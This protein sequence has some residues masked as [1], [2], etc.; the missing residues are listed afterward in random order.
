MTL[1]EDCSFFIMIALAIIPAFILGYFKKSQKIYM[2]LLS[3]LF[4][5]EALITDWK[6][7][8]YFAAYLIIVIHVVKVYLLLRN[9]YGRNKVIY[10]HFLLLSLAPLLICKISGLFQLSVFGF[11]GIS[12]I[13]FKVVQMVI[14]I[15]DGLIKE[16]KL[17]DVLNFFLFFPTFSSGPI[18]RS[19]RFTSDLNTI[20]ERDEYLKLAGQGLKK[21]M[22]GAV[23][24]FAFS[25]VAYHFLTTVFSQSYKPLYLIG[26]AYCYGI[27]MFFDFAGY[28]KMAVGISNLLSIKTPDNFKYPFISVDMNDFW[29]RWHISLSQ[30]FRDFVFSRFM[31]KS[32]HNKWFKNRLNGAA[33][34][35]IINMLIMGLWHGLTSY[36]IIYG[37]YHGV[38][39]AL[40]EIYHKKSDFYKRNKDK[41]VYKICSWF[42]TLNLVMFGFLIFSGRAN[43]AVSVALN[44][45][46]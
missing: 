9:K 22:I 34:G 3:L 42:I 15:Y 12:Y 35:L 39:L 44:I 7:I 19:R 31:M 16:I 6:Q 17:F 1:F 45:L 41:K 46:L 14:E 29:N 30:W 20:P 38:L 4:V 43:E 37:L 8:L 36:Y 13:T 33:V 18:D 24:K 23:Y 28:S 32:I 10:Y 27:Y 40:T 26:Y 5:T 25:A 21:L 2:L 11:I